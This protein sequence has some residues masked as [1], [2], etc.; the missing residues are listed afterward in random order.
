MQ[1]ANLAKKVLILFL[2]LISLKVSNMCNITKKIWQLHFGCKAKRCVCA[3]LCDSPDLCMW[4]PGSL[5]S[6]KQVMQVSCPR[7][8]QGPRTKDQG[9]KVQVKDQDQKGLL[10]VRGQ[11]VNFERTA[12]DQTLD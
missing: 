5:H 2:V 8:G 11:G 4:G 10:K 6:V 1:M 3:S 12:Q 7:Q 9:H